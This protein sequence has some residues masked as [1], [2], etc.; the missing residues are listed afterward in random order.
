MP[1][2]VYRNATAAFRG[3]L[4]EL[5]GQGEWVESRTEST[6]ELRAV[7]F[8]I[9][10]PRERCIVDSERHNNVFASIAETLWVLAGRDD[11]KYLSTYLP[12]ALEFSD[13]GATWRGAYGPRLRAWGA[14]DQVASAI[15]ILREHPL[16]RRAVI[17][18]FD[19]ARDLEPSRDIPCNNWLQFLIR[20]GKLE[21]HVV[22]RSM[23]IVWGFSGINSFEWS[24]LHELIAVALGVEV[25]TQTYFVGSL[26]LY[27]K[28]LSRAD[29]ILRHPSIDPYLNSSHMSHVTTASLASFDADVVR[30]LGWESSLRAGDLLPEFESGDH[31][32]GAFGIMLRAYWT[33]RHSGDTIRAHQVLKQLDDEG[34]AAAARDYFRW[35][36]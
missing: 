11:L 1:D 12:R 5:R 24:V 27:E 21:M 9:Q 10:R 30:L 4:T 3:L 25:G 35:N 2:R 13:D 26:H 17:S 32:L 19:P 22:A 36:H 8:S 33:W 28:H 23:D 20:D 7:T 16:S 34:L 15:E 31:L 29:A 18:I 6:Y 14:V